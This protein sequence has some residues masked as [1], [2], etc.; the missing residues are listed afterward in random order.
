[1]HEKK[2]Q[3]VWLLTLLL[4]LLLASCSQGAEAAEQATVSDV[5]GTV[6]WLEAED[7]EW[8]PLEKDARLA[9]GAVVRTGPDGS[10][11]LDF[12]D[13]SNVYL[14]SDAKMEIE[15]IDFGNDA[16][17]V[18]HVVQQS[19]VVRHA[20]H[21]GETEPVQYIVSSPHGEAR[22][23]AGVFTLDAG[24]DDTAESRLI[25][26]EGL[27]NCSSAG[28]D[29]EIAAGRM[30]FLRANEAPEAGYFVVYGQG[31]ITQKGEAWT[32]GDQ[33]FIVT[34]QT[35][36]DGAFNVGDM[37]YVEG[38][39]GEDGDLIA[40]VITLQE[41]DARSIIV[42]D[43]EIA[44]E[45]DDACIHVTKRVA[46]F[47]GT[48]ITFYDGT[49]LSLDDVASVEGEIEIDAVLLIQTCT[50]DEGV[51]TLHIYELNNN[52]QIVLCHV[53]PGNPDNEQSIRVADE[54]VDAHLA[55]GDYLGLCD[56][57]TEADIV[58]YDD[59]REDGE[60]KVLLCH[61][62]PGNPDNEHEITVGEP[63]VD[64]HLA[65]GDYLGACT[66]AGD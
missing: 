53:P 9:P 10:A 27:V 26:S 5:S 60:D 64:A 28:A 37:A 33:S 58:D 7:Q 13:E 49:T 29:V 19:G 65:H 8:Q 14:S 57:D 44:A 15:Q 22:S 31:E 20:V 4:T 43:E 2:R 32:I 1:M 48:L 36:L 3:I 45:T 62:P 25:V 59:N 17:R 61:V 40:D 16:E 38:H 42:D 21:N 41:E 12:P 51:T 56:G 66:G 39:V 24:Q 6:E 50:E 63:A 34:E 46:D 55:H 23:L 54:A 52:E 30:T 35:V 18:I 11:R 47:D